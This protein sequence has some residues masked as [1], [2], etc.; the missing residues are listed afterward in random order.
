MK[1]GVDIGVQYQDYVNQTQSYDTQNIQSGE[2]YNTKAFTIS[3]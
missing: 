3:K 2:K 1:L